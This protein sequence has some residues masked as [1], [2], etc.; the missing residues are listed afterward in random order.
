MPKTGAP[1]K[2]DKQEKKLAGVIGHIWVMS[3]LYYNGTTVGE[4]KAPSS[5]NSIPHKSSLSQAYSE[6][7]AV[8]KSGLQ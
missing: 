5:S 6:Q 8:K 4:G 3:V 2:N 7:V 1:T